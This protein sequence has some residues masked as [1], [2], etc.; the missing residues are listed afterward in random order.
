MTE[1]SS[2]LTDSDD[3]NTDATSGSRT[4]ATLRAFNRLAKRF[5]RAFL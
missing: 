2:E 1:R 4:T 5:G 3:W